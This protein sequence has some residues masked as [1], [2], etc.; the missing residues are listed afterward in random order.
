MEFFEKAHVSKTESLKKNSKS[1]E[2]VKKQ[3]KQMLEGYRQCDNKLI[4]KSENVY[5]DPQRLLDESSSVSGFSD[6][7]LTNSSN[8]GD[9]SLG[10]ESDDDEPTTDLNLSKDEVNKQDIISS[11]LSSF[12]SISEC[13]DVLESLSEDMSSQA[14]GE[15]ET[16]NISLVS[17]TIGT[18]TDIDS[19]SSALFDAD[20]AL[21][22]KILQ[23]LEQKN[24]IKKVKTPKPVSNS[25][26]NN[27]VASKIIVED[28]EEESDI[29]TDNEFRL[30]DTMK[31][32]RQVTHSK[33]VNKVPSKIIVEDFEEESDVNTDNE[34]RLDDQMDMDDEGNEGS[35]NS[36]INSNV[37]SPYISVSATELPNHNF[38][39]L[40]GDYRHSTVKNMSSDIQTVSTNDTMFSMELSEN[41][42][43]TDIDVESQN[44][45][46]KQDFDFSKEYN[47]V[48]TIESA[49][50]DSTLDTEVS[51]DESSMESEEFVNPVK[52]YYAKDS[53]I[54]VMRHPAELYIHG[55]VKLRGLGGTVEIFGYTLKD[56]FVKVYAPNYNYAHCLKTVDSE[57][58][59]Y[60]LFSKLTSAGLS[61][62]EAE[63][64]VTTIGP[65]D[66]VVCMTPLKCK[67]M[68]FV[69]GNF[70][71]TDLF[72]KANRNIN[73]NMRQPS[74]ILGCSLYVTQPM[75]LFAE[76]SSW[77]QVVKHGLRPQSRGIV[78]GG[79]GVGKSTF[80]RYSVNRLLSQGPVLVIDLDPGQSEFSVA[81]SV[82]VTVVT[83]PLLGPNF[84]HLKQPNKLLYLG[85]I[86]TMD[87]SKRYVA[88]VSM[89]IAHCHGTRAYQSMP[90]IVN[91]MGMCNTVGLNF[92]THIILHIKP[93]Y[94][95]Q[96]DSK[97]A[98]KRF[99]CHLNPGAVRN[100]YD[101]YK[102]SYL[103]NRQ[104]KEFTPENQSYE[105]SFFVCDP[106]E[107]WS[108]DFSLA[109]RDER[110][111]NYL[112]Y[113]GELLKAREEKTLLGITPYESGQKYRLG[114]SEGLHHH[115][116]S[117]ASG[118]QHASVCRLGA[119]AAGPG[120]P[121]AAGRRCALSHHHHQAPTAAYVRPP[122]TVQPLTAN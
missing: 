58:A 44:E 56:E 87:N 72:S 48:A 82:S 70:E 115:A 11:T 95:L 101:D 74:E 62:F 54:F 1:E 3:L 100:L 94:L 31:T 13:K 79:K 59:Y 19:E 119:R 51:F 64:I 76:K 81:G 104:F 6:L 116:L 112:A 26:K 73:R 16:D 90:W 18:A 22:T 92:T 9:T 118:R 117:R 35:I 113:F 40:L 5:L 57:N 77:N 114:E 60:G 93:T 10:H 41:N 52:V 15:D 55:K 110:Y 27:R 91:T 108:K 33:N 23:K 34:F 86:N 121:P 32:S 84:T 89:L 65:S 39:D 69:E 30:D 20:G 97:S 66:G 50:R 80:L 99:Q 98:K 14:S 71:N 105:Y 83:K 67:Q 29:N 7:N 17:S 24:K 122:E 21:A 106:M 96:I 102:K 85:M 46:E 49:M 38:S 4:N 78:C 75:K 2:T 47:N 61:V 109:P 42:I 88:A 120:A 45:E 8:E 103:F 43:V 25:K 68:D 107:S 37:S 12:D 28:F 63:E 36:L 53:C 111:L